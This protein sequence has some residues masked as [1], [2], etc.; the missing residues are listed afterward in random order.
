MRIIILISCLLLV[1]CGDNPYKDNKPIKV[2][3]YARIRLEIQRCN[4]IDCEGNF[5][6]MFRWSPKNDCLKHLSTRIVK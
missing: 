2:T 4:H 5:S 6:S 1:S 3:D